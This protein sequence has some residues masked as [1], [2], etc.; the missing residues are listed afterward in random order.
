[1]TN[2]FND[3]RTSAAAAIRPKRAAR[4]GLALLKSRDQ[5]RQQLACDIAE[6]E[7]TRRVTTLPDGFCDGL[8]RYDPD[9]FSLFGVLHV[10]SH[11]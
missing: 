4:F 8:S 3:P 9:H 2:P 6:F 10:G 11:G 7:Q 1:M 5:Q